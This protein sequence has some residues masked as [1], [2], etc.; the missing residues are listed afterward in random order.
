M[1]LKTLL[2]ILSLVLLS[3]CGGFEKD[4]KSLLEANENK[5]LVKSFDISKDQAEL[6]LEKEV[7]PETTPIAVIKVPTKKSQKTKKTSKKEET[8]P[9]VIAPVVFSYPSDYPQVLKDYDAVS[10]NIWE[11]FKPV[12]YQGEQSIMAISYLGVTAG[13]ITISSK[14]VVKISDKTA[15]HYFAR[16]K[17][18]DAYRYFY[19]LDDTI[20]TF[21]DKATFLPVKYSLIQREKK[22]NVDDLE[23]FD[24]KKLKTYHWYKR[25]KEGATKNEKIENYIP[26]FSQDS[27]SAL[28]F[29]RGLPLHKGDLY[30]FPVITRGKP[31]L[32][33]IEVMGEE[34]ISVNGNDLL[35]FRLKAETHFPGVLQ[36]SGDINFWYASDETRR[37]V[38]F[39]AKVKIGSIF[40]ELIEYKP[41]LPVK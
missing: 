36:K 34:T 14:D 38:K 31:W 23:L 16:F 18:K 5:D 4:K 25:V 41:G 24:F 35:A 30:D 37:L 33:K 26:R 1:N 27:F 2:T 13:Y 40:G 9:S 21:I 20:E 17:S 28:Q 11:K 29:V 22:Q 15:F 19:W 3:S 7:K 12:F 8:I 32:L 10:K 6:F 39:Q